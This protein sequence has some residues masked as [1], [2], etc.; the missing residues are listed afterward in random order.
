MT[1]SWHHDVGGQ[2]TSWC[3]EPQ[4]VLQKVGN[5]KNT[6][7]AVNTAVGIFIE[8][9]TFNAVIVCLEYDVIPIKEVINKT[10]SYSEYDPNWVIVKTLLCM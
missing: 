10:T 1:S 6:P 4:H 2:A 7:K 5:I 9:K 3:H 8:M